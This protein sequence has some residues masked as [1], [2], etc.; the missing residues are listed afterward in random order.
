MS[1]FVL[2]PVADG[3]KKE[4]KL[5]VNLYTPPYIDEE[6]F[7]AILKAN[8]TNS[9]GMVCCDGLLLDIDFDGFVRD[10]QRGKF[11]KKYEPVYEK[12]HLVGYNFD[13]LI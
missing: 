6:L 5:P 11:M 4:I 12:L 1:R 9:K 13:N 10:C 2:L 3:E 7:R 8:I